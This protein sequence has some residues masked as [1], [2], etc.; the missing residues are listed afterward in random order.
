MSDPLI[1]TVKTIGLAFPGSVNKVYASRP[2]QCK[3]GSGVR[4]GVSCL[5][6]QSLYY[7]VGLCFPIVALGIF[8]DLLRQTFAMW[9]SLPQALHSADRKLH[10]L[11]VWLPP[12]R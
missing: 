4:G 2:S 7:I 10:L 6:P 8:F 5:E 11:A 3:G 12:Q 9:P 1:L